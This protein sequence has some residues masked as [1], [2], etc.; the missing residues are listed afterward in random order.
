MQSRIKNLSLSTQKARVSL[1]E[2]INL[3][4][5]LEA[6][7][8]PAHVF[9]PHKGIYGAWTARITQALGRDAAMIK[10]IELG[11][12]ADTDMADLIAETRSLSFMSNSDAHSGDKM[13]REYNLFRMNDKS[14]LEFRYCL[15]NIN[16]RKYWPTTAWTRALANITVVIALLVN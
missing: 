13:G 15:E 2:L 3:A 7:F 12:S 10:T 11:L 4:V 9:T 16:E 6:V 5:I 14:F 1:T 8:C